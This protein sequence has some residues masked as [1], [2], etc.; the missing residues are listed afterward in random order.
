MKK[1]LPVMLMFWFSISLA[2]NNVFVTGTV[3]NV[4]S[5]LLEGVSIQVH[6]TKNIAATN[7]NGKY[8]IPA[9]TG[10][11][12]ISY[13]LTGYLPVTLTLDLQNVEVFSQNVILV[14]YVYAQS[15]DEVIIQS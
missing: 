15:L 4:Q 12:K 7:T 2:Q 5:E 13:S 6:D 8:S 10:Q 11:V 1:L 3:K 14:R 9:F